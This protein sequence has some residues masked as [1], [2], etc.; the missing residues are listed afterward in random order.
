LSITIR[1]IS[2]A[3]GLA[4]SIL[5]VGCASFVKPS[6]GS[7]SEN[8]PA[9]DQAKLILYR[10]G[11][12]MLKMETPIV[13]VDGKEIGTLPDGGFLEIDTTPGVHAFEIRKYGEE[14][15]RFKPY[16]FKVSMQGGTTQFIELDITSLSGGWILPLPFVTMTKAESKFELKKRS[17]SEAAEALSKLKKALPSDR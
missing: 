16:N 6:G 14:A 5:S 10:T 7:Y 13:L 9:S 17:A 12:A 8:K 1:K 15:W 2:L 11:G 4:L 3:T